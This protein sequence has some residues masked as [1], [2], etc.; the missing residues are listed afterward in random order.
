M[1]PRIKKSTTR[2][3]TY[4]YLVISESIRDAQGR[5]TTIDIARLGNVT[6]FDR[7]TVSSL[8]AG[9]IRLFEIEEYGLT[10]Q[11]EV[12]SC[13]EHGSI[14]LW[15]ALWQRLGLGETIGECAKRAESRITIPVEK[16][17]EMMVVNRCVNPLSKLATSRWMD[18]TCYTAMKGYAELSREVEYFYRSM[19]YLLKAKEAIEL[20]IFERLRNLFS[21]NVRLT[22]YDITST[23]FYGD[24]CAL[25]AN[26]FS[27][28]MR[29][30]RV[31]VVIGVLTSYEGYP[32]KHYVFAGNTQDQT[33]VAQVVRE[34][35]EQ[36]QV[37]DTIFVGDR[38]MISRLNLERVAAE[39][40][41]YIM[42]VKARQDEMMAMVIG[43]DA[44]FAANT[45]QWQGLTIAERQIS[46]KEFLAWK[47]AHRL[48][49][50]ATDRHTE[51]WRQVEAILA[52]ADD[53]TEPALTAVCEPLARLGNQSAT[54]R[55]AVARLLKKYKG[56]YGETVRLVCARNPKRAEL[57]ERQRAD[58][59]KELAHQL[60]TLFATAKRQNLAERTETVFQDH[61][62]RYRRFFTWVENAAGER[63]GYTLNEQALAE[64][65]RYDGVFVLTTNRH[66]LPPDKV[67]GSYKNLQEVETLFDD[68]KNF[69][70]I[71]PVRHWLERRVRAHV[72]LCLLALL[73]KRVLEIDCLKSKALTATL[74]TVANSKLTKVSVRLSD[75]S[76][77]AK[78]FWRVTQISPEQAACFAA[79]GVK[80]PASLEQYVW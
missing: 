9:L 52:A 18:T 54:Q 57:A 43:D 51:A 25:A 75:R 63:C 37:E 39:G 47:I 66:D 56:R 10:D 69:V 16:Y 11:V 34:L 42:G 27:R 60:D 76:A 46:V 30:D 48:G 72:F 31:Q 13:L 35:R 55:Q 12:L 59:L 40:Y 6:S 3:G 70:D 44:L 4:Q 80:N 77:R 64:Q 1:F 2:S 22:F 45:V 38:G 61:H 20:E 41:D 21:V 73:L 33:T 58:K 50:S 7:Q 53:Q 14:V 32:L 26:G 23:F 5:S 17:V 79:V 67:V 24:D 78:T 36:Y 74:E 62:R 49:L 65:R 28:D 19:D 68:L 71:H 8:I 29:P 15:R